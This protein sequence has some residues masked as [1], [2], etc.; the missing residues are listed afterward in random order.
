MCVTVEAR[1]PQRISEAEVLA[2]AIGADQ[3]QGVVE[4]N[5]LRVVLLADAA[6]IWDHT[7]RRHGMPVGWGQLDLRTGAGNL[8]RKQPLAR[9]MGRTLGTVVDATGGWGHDAA[10]LACMGWTVTCVERHPMLAALL[11]LSLVEAQR[12]PPLLEAIGERLTICRGESERIL[13]R[14]EEAPDVIYLD[15]MFEPRTNSALPRKPAQLLQRVVGPD[16]DAVELLT[17][18]RARCHRVVVKRP[19]DG[20]PLAAT[21]NLTFKGRLVRYDVYLQSIGG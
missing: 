10:L 12:H 1:D 18:A 19:D 11:E 17:V 13:S 9:A 2:K 16:T 15:P 7:A 3:G 14:M 21:P 6:E 8:S 5:E 20:V 4:E